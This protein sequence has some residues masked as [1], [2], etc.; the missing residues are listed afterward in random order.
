LRADVEGVELQR[1]GVDEVVHVVNDQGAGAGVFAGVS[2]DI[3]A[4]HGVLL[5][6]CIRRS[7]AFENRVEGVDELGSEVLGLV[8]GLES[9]GLEG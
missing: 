3:E 1:H 9:E 8:A 2:D 5:Q 4:G 7:H 6:C